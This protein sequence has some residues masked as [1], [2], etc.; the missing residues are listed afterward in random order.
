VLECVKFWKKF[1][2]K[3]SSETYHFDTGNHYH[4]ITLLLYQQDV[5]IKKRVVC[6]GTVLGFHFLDIP[7]TRSNN[8]QM[9]IQKLNWR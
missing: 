9:K 2:V 3:D 8:H 1:A 7:M 5:T 6:L 4:Y